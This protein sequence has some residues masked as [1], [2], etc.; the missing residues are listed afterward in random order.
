MP[1]KLKLK[2]STFLTFCSLGGMAYFNAISSMDTYLIFKSYL[3][4]F[5]IATSILIHFVW[6][7]QN[8]RA[9]EPQ[10]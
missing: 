7:Q 4:L 8:D 3:V 6:K 9:N 10:D 2:K 5:P 1:I